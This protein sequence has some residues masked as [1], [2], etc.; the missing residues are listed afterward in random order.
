MDPF[1]PRPGARLDYW[2]WKFHAGDLAFLVDL[3]VRR[4]TGRAE[5]RVSQWLRGAGRVIHAETQDWSAE[6]GRVRIGGATLQPG[7]CVGS[8]DDVSWD[9]TW[10]QGQVLSPLRGVIARLEPFDT[11]LVVWPCAVFDGSVDVGGERFDVT[12]LR[13]T[14]YHYWGRRL[15]DR[16]IWL[17]ATQIDDHPDLRV[18]GL[19]AART[20]LY[21]RVAAPMPISLLWMI[22]EGRPRE[23]VSAVNAMIRVSADPARVTVHARGILGARH[24]LT[25]SWGDVPP[26]DLGEGIIQT[27]HADLTVDGMSAAPRT[28]GLEVRGYPSPLGPA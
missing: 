8:A 15:A 11:T 7:R 6:P 17:S 28:V 25:A 26:N 10:S 2:F 22:D 20:R 24:R 5:V 14:F 1:D 23:L 19:F 3:I 4:A 21:G 18:E 27:M 13:G 9:L 12:D 16:W